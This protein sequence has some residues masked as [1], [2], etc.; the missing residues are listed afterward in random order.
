MIT[1]TQCGH[2]SILDSTRVKHQG[3]FERYGSVLQ[4]RVVKQMANLGRS[5]G[6][7]CLPPQGSRLLLLPEL[8]TGTP[9]PQP[10]LRKLP[11]RHLETAGAG[12]ALCLLQLPLSCLLN[13]ENS[14]L[15]KVHLVGLEID[16]P[17]YVL[18][19]SKTFSNDDSL[20]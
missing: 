9:Q 12:E 10:M 19:E 7:C 14:S 20:S 13:R 17:K 1:T 15:M 16:K 6:G 8:P 5:T 2:L 3:S 4:G 18:C 11:V